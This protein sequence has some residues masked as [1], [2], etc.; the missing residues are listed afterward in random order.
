MKR[1]QMETSHKDCNTRACLYEIYLWVLIY[2]LTNHFRYALN[3][4]R[5]QQRKNFGLSIKR[6]RITTWST[7]RH[8][9]CNIAPHT[10]KALEKADVYFPYTK[11]YHWPATTWMFAFFCDQDTNIQVFP[12]IYNLSPSQISYTHVNNQHIKIKLKCNYTFDAVIVPLLPILYKLIFAV[13]MFFLNFFNYL[14]TEYT[15][16]IPHYY[17]PSTFDRFLHQKHMH[18]CFFPFL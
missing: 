6:L 4:Y 12:H 8:Y 7:L 10:P 18:S 14:K 16:S 3:H 1:A 17:S 5:L 2:V 11:N 9:S 13:C 15:G